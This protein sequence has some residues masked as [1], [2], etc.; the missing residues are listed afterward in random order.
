MSDEPSVQSQSVTATPPEP[1][2]ATDGSASSP[3]PARRPRSA[4]P[5]IFGAL[6][7]AVIVILVVAY[8]AVGYIDGQARLDRAQK[9]YNSVVD[10]QNT[11][12]GA[13]QGLADK[14]PTGN[15]TTATAADLQQAKTTLD[16]ILSKAK[17]AQPQID[18]DDAALA[19]AQTQLTQDQWLTAVSRSE[20]DKTYA[21]I[22]HM[23]AALADA[24]VITSDYAKIGPFLDAYLDMA[25]DVETIISKGNSSDFSGT[26]AANEKLKTDVAKAIQLDSAPG[27]P[28][29][30]DSL[31]KLIQSLANDI[32]NLLN[33]AASLDEAAFNAADAAG[34]ADSTK[35]ESFDYKGMSDSIKNYYQGLIDAYN[36]EIDKANIG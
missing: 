10:H 34:Q 32:T 31:L 16:Q 9:A 17:D 28:T 14:L 6:T 4:R 35:L 12:N 15:V 18:S 33:A 19:G 24:K 23:R 1:S 7:A 3:T 11:L 5:L 8:V 30:M 27:L 20:L 25:V 22:G 26:A 36:A 2:P 13:V 21:K 29:S